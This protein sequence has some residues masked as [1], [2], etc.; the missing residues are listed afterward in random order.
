MARGTSAGLTARSTLE[1]STKINEMDKV[2]L[3]GRTVGSTKVSGS[4]GSNTA[5]G[6]TE[7][8]KVTR[9]KDSG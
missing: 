3:S 5:L 9:R 8:P 2:N 6:S 4:K 1:I 7:T